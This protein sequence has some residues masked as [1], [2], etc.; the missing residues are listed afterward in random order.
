[1]AL[2]HQ[3]A[4]LFCARLPHDVIL[5]VA[6]ELGA[7]D[8]LGPP[9][10]LPPLILACKYIADILTANRKALLARIFRAKFDTRAALRR[11]G[12][13]ALTNSAL[14]FQLKKQTLALRRIR[15]GDLESDNLLSDLWTAYIM[16]LEND[17]RNYPHLIEY[18]H[19]DS[20]VDRFMESRL[21]AHRE[22]LGWPLEITP[23]ALVVWLFWHTMT[24]G[25][26]TSFRVFS[27]LPNIILPE[28]LQAIIPTHRARFM[29]LLRPF[30]IA[31]LQYPTFF[32]PDNHFDF[33]IHEGFRDGGDLAQGT[34]LPLYPLYRDP[35]MITERV[36]HYGRAVSIM[37]PILGLG[38]KMAFVMLAEAIPYEPPSVL[39][40]DR[41][42]ADPADGV[43]PT[44]A[45]FVEWA[46]VRGVQLY[47]PGEWDWF[48]RL[49]PGQRRLEN[50]NA[51]RK[52][53]R[54]ISSKFDNDWNRLTGCYD[55]YRD[56]P[57][58]GVV[59]TFGSIVGMFAGR[60][61]VRGFPRSFVFVHGLRALR[62]HVHPQVP[63]FDRYRNMVHGQGM[64]DQATFPSLAE[65]PVYVRF[66]EHHCISPETPVPTGGTHHGFDDGLLNAYLP[67]SF[68]YGHVGNALRIN[69][70]GCRAA[71]RYEDYVEGKPNS[72]NPTTCTACI[73]RLE[74][75]EFEWRERMAHSYGSEM[76]NDVADESA[77]GDSEEFEARPVPR[78]RRGSESSQNSRDSYWYGSEHDAEGPLSTGQMMLERDPD[79]EALLDEMMTDDFPDDEE[80]IDNECN[81]ILDIII[82]GEVRRVWSVAVPSVPNV[83]FA[84]ALYRVDP[85]SSWSGLEQL[86]LLRTRP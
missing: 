18:A 60:M 86:P 35:S 23:N 71:S 50:D 79:A 31:P 58:K 65:F 54:S 46:A 14:A 74:Q 51:W 6:F 2:Y 43:I 68:E 78:A 10:H 73:A 42:H 49:S 48:D 38:A 26:C 15:H 81:G 55:P 9:C 85:S 27:Y 8:V 21:W 33:P 53:L 16:F 12:P 75:E 67:R 11:L 45:D 84:P 56:L 39:P 32:A 72:H 25:A 1:M 44:Q 64:P 61:Q 13:T 59:Y 17:G 70:P 30:A 36:I 76:D 20:L 4:S 37:A 83:L 47:Q 5:H 62:L 63:D 41:A 28:R 19:L 22:R 69:Y 3:P 77:V 24:P 7:V 29:D 57:L 40:I 66:R 34:A 80:Y 52:E 82:T